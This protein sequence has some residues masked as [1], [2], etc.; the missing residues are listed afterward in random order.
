MSLREKIN[1]GARNW[2]N[3]QG[4][5]T[6]AEI[7]TRPITPREAG[8]YGSLLTMLFGAG[9]ATT[10]KPPAQEDT[11]TTA[12]DSARAEAYKKIDE[13]LPEIIDEITFKIDDIQNVMV[14]VLYKKL[15]HNGYVEE[16]VFF[17]E[18][19]WSL[20]EGDKAQIEIVGNAI[21]RYYKETGKAP[22]LV[23]V[24]RSYLGE[25]ETDSTM[26][27]EPYTGLPGMSAEEVKAHDLASARA[28]AVRDGLEKVFFWDGGVLVSDVEGPGYHNTKIGQEATFA[29]NRKVTM[30]LEI[31]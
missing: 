9:C 17:D 13:L 2:L 29:G 18:K 10:Q 21:V 25:A 31:K 5:Y 12:A 16:S 26:V 28:T 7:L 22:K 20:D 4:H 11:Q 15:L 19:E 1:N 6:A 3:R 23:L 27:D 30:R 24:G 8:V 14:D